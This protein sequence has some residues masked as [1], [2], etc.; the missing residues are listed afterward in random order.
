[1]TRNELAVLGRIFIDH[2]EATIEALPEGDEK[3]TASHDAAR[4][5]H[6]MTRLLRMGHDRGDVTVYSPIDKPP[7]P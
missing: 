3:A 4:I 7:V 5:H 6:Y 2:L 1:M